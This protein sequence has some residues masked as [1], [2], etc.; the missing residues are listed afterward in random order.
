MKTQTEVRQAFWQGNEHLRR[1]YGRGKR[2]NDY[3]ATIRSE[4][5]EF[6][7]ML[8]RDRIIT[9]ELAQRVTL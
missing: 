3:N 1:F 8:V 4:W 6:V 9:E 2:Q 5:V 7:D